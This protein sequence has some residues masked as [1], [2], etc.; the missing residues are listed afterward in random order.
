M[1]ATVIRTPSPGRIATNLIGLGQIG[2]WT[3]RAVEVLPA[4]DDLVGLDGGWPDGERPS[5]ALH[6]ALAPESRFVDSA[7]DIQI[8]P[9][10]LPESLELMRQLD[11]QIGP[12]GGTDPVD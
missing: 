6:P 10:T 12:Y 9:A 1:A 5:D 3:L 2:Q 8:D 7:A 11:D 4:S